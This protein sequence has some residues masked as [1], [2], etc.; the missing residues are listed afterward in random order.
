MKLNVID[1]SSLSMPELEPYRTMRRTME[2]RSKGV[3]VAEGEKVV[4][5]L[6]ES[7]LK[8]LSVLLTK[9]WF[10][11]YSSILKKR[12]IEQ[13]VFIAEKVLLDQI[14]GYG[15]HQGIMA[16]GRV[17][18]AIDIF[19]YI[20]NFPEPRLLVAADGITNSENMG[21][22]VRNCAAFGVQVLVTD[23]TSAD[24]YLRRSVRNSMG[25][26]F[27]LLIAGVDNLSETLRRLHDEF[28][29]EI[30]AADPK[31]NSTD[32]TRIDL[33][34][35]VCVVFGS[36]GEG[37][38]HNILEQCGVRMKIPMRNNVNSINVATSVGVVLFEI[39]RQRTTHRISFRDD[40]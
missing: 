34:D 18:D 15:L 7:D 11:T 3:F 26:I 20:K 17:P 37:I 32:I 39:S 1:I 36:E 33:K 22:I 30:V 12:Q 21:V 16:L 9:E 28:S 4:R 23:R 40:S 2:H 5:R 6:V 31:E 24:P 13:G 29:F 27:K 35:D 14:V 10:E 19:S 8:I 38:S 25:T